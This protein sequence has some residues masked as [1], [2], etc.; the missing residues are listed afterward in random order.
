MYLEAGSILGKVPYPLLNIH[1]ANQSYVYDKFSYNLMNFME[2]MSDRY[3]AFNIDHSF[4]GFFLNKIPLLRRLK[5]REYATVKVLYGSVRPEN[6]PVEGSGLYYLPTN[7]DGSTASY[8]FQSKPYIEASLG[9]GN[10]FKLLR[11]DVVRRFT[12]LDHP[13]APEFGIRGQVDVSF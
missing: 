3:V 7:V 9:V 10:I 4:Y 12:Y 8:L 1:R 6:R 11:I 5:L 13:G 2:F